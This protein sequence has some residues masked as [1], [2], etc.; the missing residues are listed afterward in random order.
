MLL[1]GNK[2]T[3]NLVLQLT[4]SLT[5]CIISIVSVDALVSVKNGEQKGQEHFSS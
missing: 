4:I 3:V 5:L 2:F 1:N